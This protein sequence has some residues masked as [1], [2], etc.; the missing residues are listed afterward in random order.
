MK[1]LMGGECFILSHRNQIL[2]NILSNALHNEKKVKIANDWQ[3]VKNELIAQSVYAIPANSIE[4]NDEDAIEYLQLVGRNVQVFHQLMQEQ[5]DL[6]YLLE[7]NGI[8]VVIL[9]GA[10]AAMSYPIPENRCMGDIDIIVKPDDFEKAFHILCQNGYTN[11]DTLEK[12]HRHIGFLTQSG[13]EVELHNYFSTSDN[14][15]QNAVL[16]NLIYAAI[17]KRTVVSVCGYDASVLPTLETG[18]VLLAHINQHLGDGLGLRQVIDWM[19]FVEKYLDDKLWNSGFSEVVDSIGMKQLAVA[20]T[21]MCRKHL[22]LNAEISWD[23]L[24]DN[25]VVDELMEYILAHGNFGRKDTI[26]SKTI[27]VIRGFRNPIKGLKM[28]QETGLRTW[29]LLDRHKWL[30]P[31]AWLY[32]IC[33]WVVRGKKRGASISS[34]MADSKQE[35]YETDLLSKIGVTRL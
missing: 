23:K 2:L 33:R 25:S 6:I 32:Q 30:K 22:G 34:V 11:K 8:P 21:A 5:Q 18:I 19:C 9:K 14:G 26:T 7:N 15:E 35:Q 17:D 31:F 20:V 13:I 27:S 10:S 29:K 24:P 12:Y 16:D 28:A 4:L 1:S 3:S